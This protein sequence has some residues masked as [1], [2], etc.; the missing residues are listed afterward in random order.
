MS[1]SVF[2]SRAFFNVLA[3]PTDYHSIPPKPLVSM[4]RSASERALPSEN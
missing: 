2:F 4:C 3:N 1:L